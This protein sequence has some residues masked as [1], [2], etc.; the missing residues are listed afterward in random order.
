LKAISERIETRV[1]YLILPDFW[2]KT[3]PRRNRTRLLGHVPRFRS[4]AL[5]WKR[6]KWRAKP[7]NLRKKY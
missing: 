5:R 6:R 3:G 2:R 1:R 7:A 4:A